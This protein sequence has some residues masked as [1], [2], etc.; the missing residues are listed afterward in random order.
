M[1]DIYDRATR[2]ECEGYEKHLCTNP[3]MVKIVGEYY[4]QIKP[5]IDIDANDA[6]PDVDS[7][8]TDINILFP[9]KSVNMM[10]EN[11]EN[12]KEN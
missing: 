1:I 3:K 5:I 7:I 2:H 11:Q 9:K 8:I 4:Q 12:I 6:K 10:K